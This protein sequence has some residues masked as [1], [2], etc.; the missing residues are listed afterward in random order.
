MKRHATLRLAAALLLLCMLLTG[1]GTVTVTFD[2]NGGS[3]VSG[4][5]E[6]KIKKDETATPPTVTKEHHVFKEWAKTEDEAS[7]NIIYTAVWEKKEYNATEIHGIIEPATVEITTYRRNNMEFYLGSGFFIKENGTIVTNFHVIEESFAMTATL[8]DG[9]VYD[10]THVIAYDRDRDVAILKVDTKGAE[11]PYLTFSEELPVSGEVVYAI[12]SS[13]GLTGT[14]SSGIVSY[15]N[16]EEDGVKYIQTT[17]PISSGNSGGPLVNRYGEVI[18]M[19]TATY[20]EGQNLNLSV[21][22]SEIKAIEECNLT[23]EEF[24]EEAVIF[25]YFVGE[26]TEAEVESESYTQE[27]ASGTTVEGKLTSTEDM[28]VYL[29]PV[30][31]TDRLVM[32]VSAKDY[33]K[34]IYTMAAFVYGKNGRTYENDLMPLTEGDIDQFAIMGPED[35]YMYMMILDIPENL[36]SQGYTYFGCG[37]FSASGALDYEYFAYTITEEEYN[38]YLYIDETE[39]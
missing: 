28:D 35:R 38:T 29:T 20:T 9:T 21:A 18:G 36:Y 5:A 26:R 31:S 10:V 11:V 37:V 34:W 23:V 15:V 6:Q 16:R 1:C 19:N 4:E 2:P 39:E 3:I 14:F 32:I 13:L 12:G 22:V 27:V 7:G 25:Q 8:S 17:A 24:F 33:E 30:K